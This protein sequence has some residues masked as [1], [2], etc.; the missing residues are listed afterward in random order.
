MGRK[1][2]AAVAVFGLA[3]A[4]FAVSRWLPLSL[5]ALL[6]VGASDMVSVNIRSTLVQMAAPEAMRGRISAVNMLFIG[7]SAELGEFESGLAAAMMGGVAAVLAGGLAAL[8]IVPVWVKLFPQLAAAD[9]M[10]FT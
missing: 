2:L 9:E 6:A 3:T 4:L 7:A 10:P 5:A 1:L 8:L